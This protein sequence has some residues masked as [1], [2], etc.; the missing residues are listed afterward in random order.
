MPTTPTA[1]RGIHRRIEFE[2]TTSLRSRFETGV[3]KGEPHECWPWRGALRNGYG[4][5]KH[6]R[7]V[8]QTHVVSFVLANGPVPPGCIVTHSCDNRVC[9][10]PS[11]LSAGTCK[12]NVAEMFERL[13]VRTP[14]GERSP[15]AVLTETLVVLIK[16]FDSATGLSVSEIAKLFAAAK[17]VSE[18]Q[19]KQSI[20]RS[21]G[22][23]VWDA[24]DEKWSL[25]E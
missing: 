13:P 22:R 23:F 14:A 24:D 18:S 15:N 9:C 16:A 4:A 7:R 8:L 3:V 25:N 5:I 12:S 1:A 21:K 10:N 2:V 11:H 20:G 17:A 19:I 6:C